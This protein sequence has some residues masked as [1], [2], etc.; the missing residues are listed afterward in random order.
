MGCVLGYGDIAD[1]M[2]SVPSRRCSPDG[3]GTVGEEVIEDP[4]QRLA[5]EGD[6]PN[7][8]AA[9]LVGQDH[10]VIAQGPFHIHR[11]EGLQ[12]QSRRIG[13]RP[14]PEW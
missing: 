4:A 11:I 8:A 14:S 13:G 9:N 3:W 12:G 5:V 1:V 2:N 6:H 7:T 10:S